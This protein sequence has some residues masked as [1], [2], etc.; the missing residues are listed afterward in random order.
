MSE[1]TSTIIQCG[2]LGVLLLFL[3]AALRYVTLELKQVRFQLQELENR[4]LTGAG[5]PT[6][7]PPGQGEPFQ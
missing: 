6:V 3:V 7:P 5:L 2:A 1:T 4:L